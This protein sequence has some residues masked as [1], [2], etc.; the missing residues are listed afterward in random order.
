M[1]HHTLTAAGNTDEQRERQQV[2]PS[3]GSAGSSLNISTLL[4]IPQ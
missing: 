3:L 1:A 4:F 2:L